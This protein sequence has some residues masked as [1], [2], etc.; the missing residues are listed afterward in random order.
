MP[1]EGDE[2]RRSAV[3]SHLELADW[4]LTEHKTRWRSVERVHEDVKTLRS[5]FLG[6]MPS[7]GARLLMSSYPPSE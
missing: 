4:V 5:V 3:V 1:E 6:D 2:W 7:D